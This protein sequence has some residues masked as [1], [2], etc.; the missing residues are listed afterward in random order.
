MLLCRM[1][2]LDDELFSCY[3]IQYEV[4]NLDEI[5]V[6]ETFPPIIYIYLLLN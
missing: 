5:Y 2:F 4:Y 1:F 3:A 6:I